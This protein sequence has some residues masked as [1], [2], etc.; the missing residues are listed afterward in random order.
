MHLAV[1][2]VILTAVFEASGS[3]WAAVLVH[4]L[5]NGVGILLLRA[6]TETG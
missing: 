5:Y 1:L 2:S 3:L 6:A 4:G